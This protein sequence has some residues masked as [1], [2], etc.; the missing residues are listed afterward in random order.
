MKMV[1][2][3]FTFVFIL[4][5]ST[6]VLVSHS[7]C[8]RILRLSLLI[9]WPGDV[10]RSVMR[11]FGVERDTLFEAMIQQQRLRNGLI[12]WS[13]QLFYGPEF[14]PRCLSEKSS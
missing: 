5:F 2:S 12:R 14:A 3:V 13:G 11:N 6:Y 8:E 9:D 7:S 4:A 10:T 1:F